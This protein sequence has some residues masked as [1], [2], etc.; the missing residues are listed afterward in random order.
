MRLTAPADKIADC[1]CGSKPAPDAAADLSRSFAA[2]VRRAAGDRCSK[3]AQAPDGAGRNRL[4]RAR[5]VDSD[6]ETRER[7]M[8]ASGGLK[9]PGRRARH[10]DHAVSQLNREVEKAERQAEAVRPPRVR[11]ARAG[12]EHGAVPA[13]GERGRNRPPANGRRGPRRS[14]SARTAAGR[15]ARSTSTG[16]GEFVRF[17]DRKNFGTDPARTGRHVA[18][19]TQGD[20]MP[21]RTMMLPCELTDADRLRVSRRLTAEIK[22]R[23]QVEAAKKAAVKDFNVALKAHKAKS[24]T[25]T[26]R[27]S[28]ARSCATSRSRSAP[29]TRPGSCSSTGSTRATASSSGRSI[30]TSAKLKNGL[31]CRRCSTGGRSAS[32]AHRRAARR[33]LTRRSRSAAAERLHQER[34]ERISAGVQEAR[35]RITVVSYESAEP[36]KEW[37]AVLQYGNRV[38]EAEAETAAAPPT[39]SPIR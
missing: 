17:V 39:A 2:L 6:E 34:I 38:L 25:S 16:I 20:P 18:A 33:G 14:S 3:E 37:K 1:R 8:A 35:E 19:V 4:P 12:R 22:A 7:E 24:T 29:T 30:P 21:N 26:S 23:E 31:T 9:K 11:R 27:C 28:R 15:R 5:E 32:R 10:P 36:G 13:L